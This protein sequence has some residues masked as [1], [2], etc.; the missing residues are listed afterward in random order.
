MAR[1]PSSTPAS[2]SEVELPRR[3]RG[4]PR[5]IV[6]MVPKETTTDVSPPLNEPKKRGRKP[7]SYCEVLP[8]NVASIEATSSISLPP[9]LPVPSSPEFP[10]SSA[11]I[12]PHVPGTTCNVNELKLMTPTGPVRRS[13]RHR[14]I[15]PEAVAT[16][17]WTEDAHSVPSQNIVGEE[18]EG[19]FCSC[20]RSV[21]YNALSSET[22]YSHFGDGNLQE[23]SPRSLPL[24][25]LKRAL[26]IQELG[27]ESWL[28]SS[29]MDLVITQFARAYSSARYFSVDFARLHANDT[30]DDVTDILGRPWRSGFNF[31]SHDS[32][33][34]FFVNAQNIH[35][36][37]IRVLL[38]PQP[39]LQ[40]YEPMGMPSRNRHVGLNYRTVPKSIIDWLD[41]NLPLPDGCWINIGISVVTKAHQLTSYDCGVACLLYAEKC[42]KGQV[43]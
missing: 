8:Q 13:L 9:S 39:E 26:S 35:W 22:K 4:R 38:F 18:I 1:K 14:V 43:L 30:K 37:L 5:K 20:L 40:F 25:V 31:S 17:V 10:S 28:S 29:F 32:S 34:I 6:E 42:G 3:K 7:D 12:K 2:A 36:T 19:L 21:Q 11:S 27:D 41:K 33:L 23:P 24:V 15:Q 16:V